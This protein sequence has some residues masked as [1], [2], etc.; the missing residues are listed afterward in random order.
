MGEA[1]EFGNQGY[2][3]VIPELDAGKNHDTSM[4]GGKKPW[5]QVKSF[6]RK[7]PKVSKY[8][9]QIITAVCPY[10]TYL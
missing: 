8:M 1:R 6:R 2:K 9:I 5:F 7:A 4:F 10:S 3:P